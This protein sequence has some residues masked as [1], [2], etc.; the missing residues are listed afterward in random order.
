MKCKW[1]QRSCFVFSVCFLVDSKGASQITVYVWD[2]DFPKASSFP[3]VVWDRCMTIHKLAMTIVKS[4]CDLFW[5]FCCFAALETLVEIANMRSAMLSSF[6]RV[7]KELDHQ[8]DDMEPVPSG[9]CNYEFEIIDCSC[10]LPLQTCVA[11]YPW[12]SGHMLVLGKCPWH[13]WCPIP[14]T[15]VGVH[16]LHTIGPSNH[17]HA[18]FACVHWMTP[19][20]IRCNLLNTLHVPEKKQRPEAETWWHFC[21]ASWKG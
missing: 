21:F 20:S 11:L 3:V 7:R 1:A 9:I 13:L 17:A 5:K 12:I 16:K 8:K 18:W 2:P 15:T 10:S 4:K 19:T 14:K 6:D